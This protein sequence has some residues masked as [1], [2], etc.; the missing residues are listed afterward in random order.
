MLNAMRV[1]AGSKIIKFVIF[2][3]MVL[4]VAGLALMDVGGFYRNGG[5]SGNVVA[6]VAG[7]KIDAIQFDR[8]VRRAVSQ[9]GMMDINMAYKLGLVHQYLNTQISAVLL[10]K[11]AQEQKILI[12]DKVIAE[13]IAALVQPYAKDGMSTREAFNRVLM[14]QNMT[15]G[16]FVGMLRGELTSLMMRGSLQGAGAVTSEAE[17]K[18]LYQQRHEQR[19]IKALV[20]ENSKAKGVEKATDEILKPFYQSGQEKYAVPETR[21]FT[22]ALLTEDAARKGI[23]ISDEALKQVYEERVDEY[24]EKEK[25]LLQQALFTSEGEAQGAYDL[26]KSGKSLKEASGTSY[27]G[28]EAF[29]EAGLAKE[30]SDAA[31]AL[32]KGEVTEP[33]KTS[34][35]WHVLVMKDTVP[36]KVKSFD[37]VKEAIKKELIE[38][39]AASQIVETSNQ[40]DDALASG[41]SLDK[42]AG[43]FH[44]TLKKVGP[45]RQDGSTP[46][47][48]EGLADFAKTRQDILEAAFNLESG[49]TSSVQELSDGTY[50]VVQVENVTAKNYKDFDSVKD[51][52]AKLWATDQQDII[53]RRQATEALQAAQAGKSLEEIAKETGATIRTLTI[54]NADKVEA[55]MTEAMKKLLF[56]NSK[57]QYQLT[58]AKDSYV[59]AIVTDVKMPDPAKAS[60]EDIEA[61]RE[62]AR[63]NGQNEVLAVYYKQLNDKYGVK[64]NDK[65]LARLFDTPAAEQQIQ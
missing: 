58:P 14:S 28:E 16:E 27:I 13:R 20:F 61:L 38:E 18:A 46:D 62:E 40:V 45:V 64:I 19:T 34:L 9:Q 11:D 32:Q 37:S 33:V 63:L 59:L 31:F 2:S 7:Q 53:S 23:D 51:E 1:G 25:R 54:S 8:T 21:I 24:T 47:N 48:K 35:G 26:V 5:Q 41:D 49:E 22:V 30:I 12:D 44:L 4:A 52:L 3:F 60:K 29:E 36:A 56:E 39:K 42:V 65:T 57:G 43:D 6:T 15:E 17:I 10:Q 50:A 55:P